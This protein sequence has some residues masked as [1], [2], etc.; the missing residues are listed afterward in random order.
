[1]YYS[2][3]KYFTHKDIAKTMGLSLKVVDSRVK[4]LGLKRKMKKPNLSKTLRCKW[5]KKQ[6]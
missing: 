4:E 5:L 3:D 1:L 6:K 2:E